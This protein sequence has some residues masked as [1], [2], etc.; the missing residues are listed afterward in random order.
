M[1]KKQKIA[2][3]E[4]IRRI[5]ETFNSDFIIAEP[6]DEYHA[7]SRNG[8]FMSSHLLADFRES[9]ALYHKKI[10]GKLEETESAVFAL[11]KATHC[12]ILEGPD[13]FEQEYLIGDGPVNPKTGEPFGKSTKAYIEWKNSLDREV[14]SGK[15]FGFITKLQASVLMHPVAGELLTDGVAEGVVRAEYC[16]VPCQIRMDWFSWTEG[17][18]DLKTCDSLKW[19]ESDCR[20]YGYIHQ[21]AFYRAVIRESTGMT[22]PVH[23][24]AV[25]KNE[26]FSTGVWKLT[27]EVLDLAE[28]A[29]RSALAHFLE[30]KRT[31]IWP[32]GY[33][34]TRIINTL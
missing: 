5:Q 14:V 24:I 28:Q 12:A 11:G 26:P 27:D 25:E 32:T 6:A 17:I 8:E 10:S 30:C 29:N 4:L 3:A 9:P 19:F 18:V 1:T 23:I 22:F 20:R 2:P 34:E 16:G 13:I 7:R 33:E 21:M 15:D 31:N